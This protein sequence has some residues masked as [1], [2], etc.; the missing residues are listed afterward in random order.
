M[1]TLFQEGTSCAVP[2]TIETSPSN[3]SVDLGQVTLQ[4]SASASSQEHDL[5]PLTGRV[6]PPDATS[7]SP[8]IP[9]DDEVVTAASPSAMPPPVTPPPNYPAFKPKPPL[10]ALPPHMRKEN[11]YHRNKS[12][13]TSSLFIK[14]TLNDPDLNELIMWLVFFVANPSN[15]A[16]HVKSTALPHRTRYNHTPT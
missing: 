13:S 3:S 2:M 4:E 7:P 11:F 6:I 12:N 16:K 5:I 14:H 15:L 10:S 9:A 1:L 8:P